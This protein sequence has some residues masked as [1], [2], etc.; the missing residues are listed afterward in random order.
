M[1]ACRGKLGPCPSVPVQTVFE[2]AWHF[3]GDKLLLCLALFGT[4]VGKFSVT[5]PWGVLSFAAVR[6]NLE[7]ALPITRISCP[8][9]NSRGLRIADSR[10]LDPAFPM[11]IV[12]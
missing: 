11:P 3:A 6:P 5:L 8:D 9:A 12:R 4:E 2:T 7:G 10:P 1:V